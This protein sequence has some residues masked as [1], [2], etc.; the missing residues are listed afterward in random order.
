MTV[1]E[2]LIIFLKHENLGQKRFANIIG[3]SSGYVN[4]IKESIQPKTIHKIAMHFPH[5]NTGWL[6]T[7]EG[8]M[9]KGLESENKKV[10]GKVA[11][12]DTNGVS[13]PTPQYESKRGGDVSIPR[14]ILELLNMQAETIR[15]QQRTI[16][17]LEAENKKINAQPEDNEG[18]VSGD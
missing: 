1:K 7:G 12:S 9:L 11:G 18:F 15:S 8:E 13:E 16:E 2:R 14:E 17:K 5:L 4:A 6:L 3:M 10:A